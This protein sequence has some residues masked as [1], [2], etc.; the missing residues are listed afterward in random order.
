LCLQILW[1]ATVDF[2]D[3]ARISASTAIGTRTS[4]GRPRTAALVSRP[5][6]LRT[7]A[8]GGV[9][10]SLAALAV[11]AG[12]AGVARWALAIHVVTAAVDDSR[13][14]L[15]FGTI[16]T[17]AHGAVQWAAAGVIREGKCRTGADGGLE[18]GFTGG[19]IRAGARR[20]ADPRRAGHLRTIAQRNAISRPFADT[21]RW[22]G[23]DGGTDGR[24]TRFWFVVAAATR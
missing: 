10:S 19:A 22:A 15:A 4:V 3:G 11:A 6:F 9:R 12:A 5:C 17:G 20:V 8:N 13:R 7:R 16:G 1:T 23:A 21:T 18:Q 24:E 2:T 14:S